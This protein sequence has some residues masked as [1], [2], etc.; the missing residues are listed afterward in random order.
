MAEQTQAVRVALADHPAGLTV[1][2]LAKLFLKAN[3]QRV[4]DL[5]ET[6]IVLGQ[7]RSLPGDRFVIN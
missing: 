3:R 7:A 1:E 5:L 6:L 4:S 2:E